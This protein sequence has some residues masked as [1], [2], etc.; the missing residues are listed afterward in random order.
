MQIRATTPVGNISTSDFGPRFSL[1]PRKS[2]A[3][4]SAGASLAM[5]S[6]VSYAVI[7]ATSPDEASTIAEKLPG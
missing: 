6:S 4:I 7:P 2:R 3:G 5:N 1:V